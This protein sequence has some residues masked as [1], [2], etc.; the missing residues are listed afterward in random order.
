MLWGYVKSMLTQQARYPDLE[1]REFLRRYQRA[2]LLKGK[3]R[4]TAALNSA[5]ASRWGISRSASASAPEL[6]SVVTA[7]AASPAMTGQP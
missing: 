4:A 1:F 2:C 5:Q 6:G 3:G 7:P